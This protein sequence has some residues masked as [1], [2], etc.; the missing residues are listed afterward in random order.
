MEREMLGTIQCSKNDETYL[1]ATEM[2]IL[3]PI[4]YYKMIKRYILGMEGEKL[5]QIQFSK[6]A[7]KY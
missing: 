2:E 4:C 3:Y 6:N 5:N 7:K 1:L